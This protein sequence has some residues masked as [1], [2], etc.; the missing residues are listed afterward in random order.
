RCQPLIAVCREYHLSPSLIYGW[1]KEVEVRGVAAFTDEKTA[2]QALER[3]IAELERYCGQL[4]LENTVLKK[5]LANY[6]TRSG[7]K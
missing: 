7:S 5:S 1:R 4:A 2:D 6:R 3:R